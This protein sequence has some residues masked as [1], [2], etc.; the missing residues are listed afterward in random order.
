MRVYRAT[1][2]PLRYMKA[3]LT[4]VGFPKQCYQRYIE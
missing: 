3:P 4:V 2:E 1:T